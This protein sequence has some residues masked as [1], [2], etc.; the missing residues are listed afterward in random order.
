MGAF[1]LIALVVAIIGYLINKA[2][3]GATYTDDYVRR[4]AIET[5]KLK[6]KTVKPEIKRES[7]IEMMTRYQEEHDELEN[8]R[9][10]P[11]HDAKFLGVEDHMTY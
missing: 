1:I 10:E 4:A 9:C 2:D 5:E 7:T 3:S 8:L 6:P 11:I